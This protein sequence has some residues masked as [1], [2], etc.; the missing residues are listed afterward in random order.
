MSAL[1]PARC[2]CPDTERPAPPE[3]AASVVRLALVGTPNCGKTATFNALTGS[4]QKVA[5]YA[6]VT[7]E[8]KEGRFCTTGGAWVSVLD[9]PGTSSLRARSPDE[10]ITRDVV[11]GQHKT[12]PQPDALV[13]VADAT[14]LLPTICLLLE[15]KETGLPI[16]LSVNMMDIARARGRDI[17]LDMLSNLLGVPAV[18]SV[19]VRRGGLDALQ[20]YICGQLSCWTTAAGVRAEKHAQATW[21]EPDAELIRARH[22]EAARILAAATLSSGKPPRVSNAIDAV[23]LH[24]VFGVALLLTILFLIFQAV[25]V[26]AAP[27]M[28]GID[29]GFKALSDAVTAALPDTWLRGL[30]VDG[31]IAG[32]GGVLVFLPQ[33]IILFTCIIFLEDFGYMARAAFLMDRLMG[34]VGLHGR[35]FIP[36]LSSFACAIPGIMATRTIENPK[37][38][39]TTILIAP[40]MTCSARLPVYTLIIGALIPG[41]RYG[42]WLSL[43]GLVMFGLYA[44][45]IVG[46]LIVALIVKRGIFKAV[47]EPLMLN[48]PDY[49][50]PAWK[51]IFYGVWLRSSMFLK[52]AGTTIFAI[53]VLLWALSTWPQPP[54]GATL[55]AIDYSAAGMLGHWLAPLMEP[56]GFTWQMT[57]ALIPAMAAREVAVAALG[58]IYA[59]GGNGTESGVAESLGA[60]LHTTWTLPSALAF[61]AWFVFAPQC[62]STLA[63]VRRETN[64]VKWPV[65]MFLYM[66]A[67]AYAAA[68]ATFHVAAWAGL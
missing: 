3:G 51:N 60:L 68:F 4:R 19:A 22:N 15:L 61:L 2:C 46:A 5:N 16:L 64:S 30:I 58:T 54:E 48:L 62:V 32:V 8:R 33:I 27:V 42:G 28:D 31:V 1:N 25:F 37:D 36:L 24:P 40:L 39:I 53:A 66:T 17:D 41:T 45:G 13:C 10:A 12:E 38:R 47:P 55:P 34:A 57:L 9:L 49:K 50:T 18:A 35:A 56:I 20:S 59:V 14:N 29:A 11:L 6:G 67:L 52:R 43:Q 65:V 63:V 23:T 21:R 26:G 44:T 7:V